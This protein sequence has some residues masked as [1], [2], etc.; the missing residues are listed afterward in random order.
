MLANKQNNCDWRLRN[1]KKWRKMCPMMMSDDYNIL[2][3]NSWPNRNWTICQPF[4]VT[5]NSLSAWMSHMM[6]IY[7]RMIYAHAHSFHNVR[8]AVSSGMYWR[9]SLIISLVWWCTKSSHQKHRKKA[10]MQQKPLEDVRSSQFAEPD[11]H[12]L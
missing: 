12:N 1:S 6:K 10:P 9:Q 4:C 8:D 11:L 7:A 5:K 3:F 2:I